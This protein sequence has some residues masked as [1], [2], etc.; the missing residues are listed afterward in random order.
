L[1][2]RA[3]GPLFL[4]WLAFTLAVARPDRCNTCQ[5]TQMP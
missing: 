1:R 3:T 2:K 4:L 5:N